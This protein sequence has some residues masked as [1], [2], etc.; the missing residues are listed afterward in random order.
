MRRTIRLGRIALCLV[1]AAMLFGCSAPKEAPAPDMA[2]NGSAG[3]DFS[4]AYD[5]ASA[6][7]GEKGGSV[8]A[9]VDAYG[10]H[11]RIRYIDMRIETDLF[12][13]H[14]NEIL[15]KAAFHGGYV[16]K[17]SVSG[18][19]PQAYNDEGR[20]ASLTLR[21]PA[22]KVDAFLN[23]I[24]GF[25][26][27]LYK[28]E[29]ADDITAQYFDLDTRLSVLRTQHERLTG[30]L[31]DT[32]NLADI[33]MLESEIAKVTLEIEKLT[34]EL[35]RYDD[36]VAYSSITIELYEKRL[37]S[38][39]ASALSAGE[40]IKEGFA[41]SLNGIAVFFVDLFVWLISNLPV[42]VILAAVA[43]V[44][45]FIIRGIRRKKAKAVASPDN[46][47]KYEE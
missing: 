18:R 6:P 11:K 9:A 25:G 37:T 13:D 38:G 7:E 24:T 15:N 35:N 43:A 17:S 2:R 41:N 32:D 27:V 42:L 21:V 12:D 30:I 16:E 8:N 39:P 45:I 20:T 29:R 40:R 5:Q 22:D 47:K 36:L 46:N 4:Q 23:E 44:V 26:T 31:V 14:H 3:F 19:P 28:N 34:T 10:G 1:I 33:L